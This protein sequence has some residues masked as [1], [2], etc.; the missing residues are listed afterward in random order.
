MSWTEI[1]R[2]DGDG[3][4]K[5]DRELKSERETMQMRRE[6]VEKDGR[7]TD[8]KLISRLKRNVPAMPYRCK[9][10]GRFQ[11]KRW[12]WRG[13]VDTKRKRKERE[14]ESSSM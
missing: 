3:G 4:V 5:S 8:A 14:R 11:E 2:L 12:K 6:K 13:N 9:K 7:E 1:S 10:R